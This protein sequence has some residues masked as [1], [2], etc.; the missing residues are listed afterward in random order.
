[1]IRYWTVLLVGYILQ[2][3]IGWLMIKHVVVPSM[4][5]SSGLGFAL[6]GVPMLVAFYIG[7]GIL[8]LLPLGMVYFDF[9]PKIAVGIMVLMGILIMVVY[10]QV[11]FVYG[12][13]LFGAAYLVWERENSKVT[14][15]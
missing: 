5:P 14:L 15:P 13:T 9:R 3:P 1:M 8:S 12:L 6:I 2:A 10:V 11:F 7:A 4:D